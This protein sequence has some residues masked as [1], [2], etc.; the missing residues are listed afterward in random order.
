M[1]TATLDAARAHLTWRGRCI[2]PGA[3]QTGGGGNHLGRKVMRRYP[4]E[5]AMPSDKQRL[6]VR[7]FR[8]IEGEAEGA[9]AI[10][11]LLVIA[12]AVISAGVWG[13]RP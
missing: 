9:L 8:L 3:L 10:A 6:T 2:G 7:I 1:S 12:L 13:F 4:G 11:V 5:P